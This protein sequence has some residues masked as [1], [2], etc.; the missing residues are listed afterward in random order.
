MNDDRTPYD[1]LGVLFAKIL[2]PV[3]LYR[4]IY[5]D[6]GTFRGKRDVTRAEIAV[7]VIRALGISQPA[8]PNLPFVDSQAVPAWAAGSVSRAVEA[9]IITG[10]PDNTF[11]AGENATRAQTARMVSRT[12]DVRFAR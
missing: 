12:L 5:D 7:M 1:A 10:F 3:A 9:G 6:D 4:A 11:R 2:E 8:V